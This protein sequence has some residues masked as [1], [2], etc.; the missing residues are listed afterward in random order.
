MN[1]EP[2]GGLAGSSKMGWGNDLKIYRV[3][4]LHAV[5]LRN[6]T[7]NGGVLSPLVRTGSEDTYR[8]GQARLFIPDSGKRELRSDIR[9]GRTVCR[10]YKVLHEWLQVLKDSWFE[11]SILLRHNAC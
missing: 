2:G 10:G 9:L 6:Q 8:M 3:Q 7:E 4:T 1:C 11:Q 5:S